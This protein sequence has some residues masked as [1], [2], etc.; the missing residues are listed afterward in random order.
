MRKR[1]AIRLLSAALAVTMSLAVCPPASARTTAED[2][3]QRLNQL[4]EKLNSL[5]QQQGKEAEVQ[6]LLDQQIA[7]LNEDLATYQEQ[8]SALNTEISDGNAQIAQL[9]NQILTT[10]DKIEAKTIEIEQKISQKEDTT[11]LLKKRIRASYMAGQTST[12][13]V[14]LSSKSFGDFLSNLEYIKRITSHD[15]DLIDTLQQQT[16]EITAAR[17]ELENAKAQ[18]EQDKTDKEVSIQ[19]V[20]KK[21]NEL[22]EKQEEQKKAADEVKQRLA[23]SKNVSNQ[24]N[25]DYAKAMEDR[26]AIERALE[27]AN[28]EIDRIGQESAEKGELTPGEF[29]WPLPGHSYISSPYGNRTGE[30]SGFHTGIDIPAPA[31]T[32]IIASRSGTVAAAYHNETA[33]YGKYVVID[34][35]GGYTT[36]Y[37]HCSSLDVNVG[38]VV[39]QGQP[40][41]KVGSTGNSTGN[42]LHFE[43]RIGKQNQNPQNYVTY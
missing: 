28:R 31:G 42:H 10:Q 37:A 36:L 23:Q 8:I 38:D 33:S 40:I 18:I 19:Q 12:L 27:E 9:D 43:V 30:V 21:R 16:D 11:S 32:T 13:D 41:A 26:A 20:E 24:L 15:Q 5:Q 2:Y 4:N 34:H 22:L 1:A 29:I 7:E 35:G 14:L 3:Q 6:K 17:T 25:Q 39:T